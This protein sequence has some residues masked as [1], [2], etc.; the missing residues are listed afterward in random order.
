MCRKVMFVLLIVVSAAAL[1]ACASKPTTPTPAAGLP[2]PASVYCEQNSGKVGL[3]Q[4]AS[5]G[6]AGRCVF[7]DGSVCDEWAY[8]RGTCQPGDSLKISE[9]AA[10]ALPASPSPTA[11]PAASPSPMPKPAVLRVA[12]AKAGSIMLW[13]E[14]AVSR[15]LAEATN[16]EQVRISDDGQTVAYLGRNPSGVY[17]LSAVH[18][19]GSGQRTLV[20]QD[21][22]QTT[23]PAGNIV[24]FDFAPA[25]HSLY[26]ATDQYDLHRVDV[27][28][29][30]PVLM[31]AAGQG[32][33]FSFSPDGQ[34]MTLYHP[35]ELA[36]AHLDG[37]ESRVVF[38]YPEDFRYT[39]VGP[40]IIWKP[41]SSGFWLASASGPQ[42]TP[43]NMTVWF[44][45]VAGEPA[46]QRSYTGPYGANLSP[47]GRSLVYLDYQHE[48]VD[49]HIIT[50]DGKDTLYG[51]YVNVGFM[52]W[53]PD[54][55]HF[56]L[57]LSEDQRL[58]VPFLCA[59]GEQPAQLTDTD[60]AL[61]VAWI[62]AEQVVF[63]S[64]GK[65]LRLQR[66]GSPSILLDADASSWFDYATINP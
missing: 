44:I 63:A 19:D 2:N 46:K 54:S 11:E 59:A 30:A 29:G 13:S 40:E 61:P 21:Y 26:F 16:V 41:D 9:P 43:D 12:Y 24:S 22:L 60:D 7:P 58:K 17:E 53:A 8:F 23:Q 10:S 64:H 42:G 32:G 15:Q 4:D 31:F 3:I 55:Q 51:S 52:G 45:P 28:S 36:L 50:S 62:D 65:A 14:G 47:D 39:M 33:F 18:A 56:L 1:A 66:L 20:G 35:N 48:P 34:W 37:T 6:V 49:V 57:S 25:S 27:A 5:G 38:R